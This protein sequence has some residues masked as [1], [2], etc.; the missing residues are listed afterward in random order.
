MGTSLNEL[1]IVTEDYYDLE[2]GKL[3]RDIYFDTSFLLNYF[4]KQQKGIWERPTGG[5][6]LKVPLEYDGQNAAFYEKGD[7]I[8]SDDREAITEVFF[9]WKHVYG[10]STIYRIDGLKNA[11]EYAI[12]SLVNQSWQSEVCY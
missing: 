1:D 9:D 11:G 10:N 8:S 12:V 4:I 2:D 3:A 5:D 7:T 6:R